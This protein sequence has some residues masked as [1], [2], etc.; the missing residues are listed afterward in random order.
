MKK[1]TALILA[2]ILSFACFTA[3]LGV[4]NPNA[5]AAR[6][7]SNILVAYFS[8]TETTKGIAE[9]LIRILGADSYRIEPVEPY[10]SEDLNYN[11]S[12]SRANREQNDPGARPAISGVMADIAKYDAVLLGYPI[13]WGQSPKIIYTFLESYDFSGK[14][15]IP[16]CTS[17]SSGIS[18]SEG[19]LRPLASSAKWLDGKRFA[20]GSSEE[21]VSAWVDTLDLPEQVPGAGPEININAKL[22]TVNHA[23]ENAT[24]IL[25]F[26]KEGELIRVGTKKGS[27]TITEAIGDNSQDA[28]MLK[29][30]LWDMASIK[31]LCGA[32]DLKR[33]DG[34]NMQIKV[35]SAAYEIIYALNESQA[36]KDLY[37][38]LPLT[39]EVE[40]FSTNEKIFYP[41]GKLNTNAAPPADAKK[42]TLAYFAPWGDVVMYYGHYGTGSG[43]YALG[44]AVSGEDDIEKLSGMI[45]VTA[46]PAS[47]DTN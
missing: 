25:A 34:G 30:F 44:E 46:Y 10:T 45:T 18:G 12:S 7:H 36:A 28:D 27:G 9:H 33:E 3:C 1:T 8:C 4:E 13:W 29:A 6:K 23:P 24:L 43:L 14:T 19:G 22:V 5:E 38:Q 41:P 15:I 42:G 37:A 2:C 17:G 40:N 47:R 35:A 16:F 26:Y 39:L 11:A 31:P 32:V 20:G 21:T